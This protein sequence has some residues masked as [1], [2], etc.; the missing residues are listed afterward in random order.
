M[1]MIN[2]SRKKRKR[3][4]T[5]IPGDSYLHRLDPRSKLFLL[6]TVSLC[7]LL[8]SSFILMA[9]IFAVVCL[10]ALVSGVLREWTYSLRF[11][12]PLLL[13][14]VIIDAFFAA[15]YGTGTV[16][17]A[18][19]WWIFSPVLTTGRIVF[20]GA[21]MFRLLSIGGFSF[22]FIMTTPYNRFIQSLRGM[23]LPQILCFSLGYALRSVTQLSRDVRNIM[24]A[25]RSRGFEYNAKTLRKN[26][27]LSLSLAIPMVVSVLH[28]SEQVSD[29]MQCRGYG[30]SA[31]P[32]VYRPVSFQYRDW[33]VLFGSIVILIIFLFIHPEVV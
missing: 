2:P 11:F 26:P 27:E 10:L 19:H 14:V 12:V 3:G 5:Y 4:I 21:M 32:S 20:A 29:A 28:R 31:S 18:G 9:V 23:R 6:I 15:D 25:Q 16:I 8:T 17:W 7:S 22:L 24:D 1:K 13:F 33:I 30:N